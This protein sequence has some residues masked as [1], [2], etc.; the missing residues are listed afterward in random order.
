MGPWRWF[1][2]AP[3]TLQDLQWRMKL[4]Y[5]WQVTVHLIALPLS[6]QAV[7]PLKNFLGWEASLNI[8]PK[9]VWLTFPLKN[10]MLLHL[11]PRGR[12]AQTSL[13]PGLKYLASTCSLKFFFSIY[14]PTVASHCCLIPS[15]STET[16]A[17][18]S[19]FLLPTLNSPIYICTRFAKPSFILLD[20]S[21]VGFS[22]VP[23]YQN[24]LES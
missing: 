6:R 21:C 7:S 23:A 11:L 15:F 19:H 4:Q 5:C 18:S 16:V 24:P 10:I 20:F 3:C 12:L 22:C 2:P 9:S 8:R 14:F 1:S 13:F 17:S